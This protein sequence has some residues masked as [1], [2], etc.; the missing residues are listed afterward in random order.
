M[1]YQIGE[2]TLGF[3]AIFLC[4]LLYRTRLIPRLLAGLGV[5]GYVLL[6]AGAI[7]ELFGGHIDG[8]GIVETGP[9]RSRSR[10]SLVGH[11]EG[12]C[13]V[14]RTR[15]PRAI[16]SHAGRDLAFTHSPPSQR[17]GCSGRAHCLRS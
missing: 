7:V 4:W 12:C 10:E 16:R 13:Q 2:M 14:R 8:C 5:I 9:R 17:S 6:M 11:H 3:G 1:A 15:K